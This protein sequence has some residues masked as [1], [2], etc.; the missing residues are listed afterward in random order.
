MFSY[1][2]YRS[3]CKELGRQLTIR[4]DHG[5][6]HRQVGSRGC[7]GFLLSGV[8]DDLDA[9][10]PLSVGGGALQRTHQTRLQGGL[11]IHP[12]VDLQ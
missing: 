6:G 7:G 11:H 3:S 12:L 8:L 4:D 10:P 1:Q 9:V 5:L 2:S